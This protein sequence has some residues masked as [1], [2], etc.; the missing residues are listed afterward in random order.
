M[1]FNNF[2][3]TKHHNQTNLIN[4]KLFITEDRILAKKKLRKMNSLEIKKD[5]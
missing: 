5:E 3:I 1:T 4:K 2:I